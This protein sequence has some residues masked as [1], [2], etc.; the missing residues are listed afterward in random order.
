MQYRLSL[1][2]ACLM[3]S[4]CQHETPK[5]ETQVQTPALPSSAPILVNATE[6]PIVEPTADQ[7]KVLLSDDFEANSFLCR[8]EPN[9][10]SFLLNCSGKALS[11]S[12][13]DDRRK[14][15]LF[16]TR[17]MPAEFGSFSL[18]ME[19]ISF[20]AEKGMPDQ[21]NYGF[22]FADRS[23]LVHA[24]RL[25]AQYFGFE[26]WSRYADVKVEEST[27]PAFSPAIRSAGQSNRM[28]LDCSEDGCDL[29]ANG[30]LAGRSPIGITGKTKMIGVFASSSWDQRFG[31]VEFRKLR[32]YKVES[33]IQIKAPYSIEDPLSYGSDIFTGTG[34]SG[35][36]HEFDTE[37]FH[38][39]PV[40]PYGFYGVKAG[41]GM[42]NISVKAAIKM[43][44]KPGT[45]GS[46]FAGLV[47]RSSL[48]GMVIAVIRVDGTFSI[49]RDTPNQP[50][51]L[52]AQRFSTAILPGLAENKLRLDCIGDQ[53]T[54]FINGAQVESLTSSRYELRYGR[55][56]LFTKAGGAPEPDAIIFSDLGITEIR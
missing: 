5:P 13:S 1:I 48:D 35:A 2:A 29:Y 21:N 54:F 52:L 19:T 50:F 51:A 28:R 37:G 20:P 32:I 36:F 34:L 22:Y 12:Q 53:I 39:S 27:N 15:D 8:A 30:V 31:R 14:V 18:E 10:N 4:T 6:T 56:G 45:S 47:C 49:Y 3:V 55:A 16:I 33:G 11:I 23:G 44:I 43:E 38:F 17:E 25:S 24:I 26:T 42:G 46:Q 9:E 40:I 41:P 7:R